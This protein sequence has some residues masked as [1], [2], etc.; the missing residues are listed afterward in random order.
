[1][2]RDNG[3]NY[4]SVLGDRGIMAKTV[5]TT[6]LTVVGYIG[7]GVYGLAFRIWGFRVL[8]LRV[9]GDLGFRV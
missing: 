8:G 6:I 2:F 4:Y 3:T 5:E 9:G 7:Y 1:M